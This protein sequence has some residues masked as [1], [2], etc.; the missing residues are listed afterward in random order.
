MKDNIIRFFI[1]IQQ[2]FCSK[3]NE[4]ESNYFA[5]SPIRKKYLLL[6]LYFLL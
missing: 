3:Y 1:K 5:K 6:P 4:L 2:R